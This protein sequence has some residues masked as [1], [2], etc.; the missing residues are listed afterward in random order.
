MWHVVP[1][2]EAL[3]R[4]WNHPLAN[5]TLLLSTTML[6]LVLGIVM[7]FSASNVVTYAATEDVG[8]TVIQKQLI[9]AVG[10]LVAMVLISRSSVSAIRRAAPYLLVAAFVGLFLVF[11]PGI[12]VSVFGQ[13][14][15][16]SFGGPF[17]FQPSELAKLAIIVWGA[18]LLTRK[19][20]VIHEWRHLLVPLVPV[21]G[22]IV[23]LIVLEGDLGTTIVMF[24]ILA[25]LLFVV[26]AP[27][28]VFGIA[29]GSLVALVALAS[30]TVSYRMQRFRTW[31]DP[32]ADPTGG[33]YQVIHGQYGLA[34]GGLAGTGLGAS[35]EKWGGLPEAH[36]D[37]IFAVIGEELGLIGSVS[38]LV[39][40][41][42]VT[43]VAIRVARDSDDLFVK[44]ATGGIIA[45][46]VGQALVNIGAVLGVLPITGLPLPM[47]SYGGSS[48]LMCLC[49]MGVLLAFARAEP[50]AASALRSRRGDAR[51]R[52]LTPRVRH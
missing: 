45:W 29:F 19:R 41:A 22:A 20:K 6:L 1:G 24:P 43:I 12:G 7:V 9:F 28:R 47:V 44:L 42:I 40:F 11:V 14:N 52:L 17:Q 16:I 32:T 4:W 35:R 26:G 21:W 3:R 46:I 33:G 10:G 51:T 38:V 5:Y 8:L 36:T 34:T 27:G 18:D 37:F 23:V 39:M 31:L 13:R 50:Q 25:S 2:G 49:A 30:V 48:L 15:W